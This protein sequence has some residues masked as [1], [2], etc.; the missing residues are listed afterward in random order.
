MLKRFELMLE[1][2]IR[3]D[4]KPSSLDVIKSFLLRDVEGLHDIGGPVY[5]FRFATASQAQTVSRT[6][7]QGTSKCRRRNARERDRPS[8][9]PDR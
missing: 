4:A 7:S 1:V 2:L 5:R 8:A 3:R 6:L 9:D